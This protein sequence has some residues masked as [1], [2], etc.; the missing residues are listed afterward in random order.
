MSSFP[1]ATDA[2]MSMSPPGRYLKKRANQGS[3]HT[4]THRQR[5]RERERERERKKETK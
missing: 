4:H 5:E 1:L 3:T 2:V